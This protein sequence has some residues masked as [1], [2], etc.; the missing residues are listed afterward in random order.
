MDPAYA[1]RYRDLAIPPLVVAGPQRYSCA[2]VAARL[3]GLRRDARHPRH[4]LRR[5]RAVSVF[6][7]V[8]ATS[9]ASS[10]TP[11][12]CPMSRRGASG[13]RSSVRRLVRAGRRYDLILMLDV[14]EHIEDPRRAL[15]H[16]HACSLP[17]AGCCSRCRRFKLLWT[18]HDELN[19]HF[20]LTRSPGLVWSSRI[21]IYACSRAGTVPLAVP[22]EARRTRA[23]ARG[24]SLAAGGSARRAPQRDAVSRVC[25]SSS[26]SRAGTCRS[27][28]RFLPSLPETTRHCR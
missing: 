17:T 28:A 4:R 7:Q 10:P 14:L 12:S 18:H 8:S 21:G 27:G 5:W 2:R 26:G 23:R 13:S 16:V 6:Q 9:K 20:R 15:G 3:L 25:R 24:W 11:A 22:G 19:R 1:Q